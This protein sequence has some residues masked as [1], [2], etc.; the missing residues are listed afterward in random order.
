MDKQNRDKKISL[1]IIRFLITGIV[2]AIAD[3]LTSFGVK[4]ALFAL[5]T[6]WLKIAIYTFCG[7]IVGVILNYFLST[8]WVF[9]NVKDKKKTKTAGFIALY[10]LLSAIGWGLSYGTMQLC[11]I[12]FNAWAGVDISES[13]IK[14][15]LTFDLLLTAHFWLY[16]LAFGLKT[17]VGMVWN[18]LTRKFIL[19]KAPKEGEETKEEASNE[20]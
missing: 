1:E 14:Q 4:E 5:E 11:T 16:V 2:C 20:Q 15:G 9:K 17:F 12:A 7:F 6:E 18:Y 19:Y 3:F 8:Y 10:V 13:L